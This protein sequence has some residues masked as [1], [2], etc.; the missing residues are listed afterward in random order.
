MISNVIIV[1][2][3]V[4][5]RG[6]MP[7]RVL[8][9]TVQHYKLPSRMPF[10]CRICDLFTCRV[11]LHVKLHEMPPRNGIPKCGECDA[12]IYWIHL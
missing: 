4:E 11:L 10:Q 2:L 6:E 5:K 1:V 3:K 12:V 8:L 7:Y 9:Y